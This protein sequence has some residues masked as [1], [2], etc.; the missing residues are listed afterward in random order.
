MA[1]PQLPSTTSLVDFLASQKQNTSFAARRK[2]Y[3]DLGFSRRLGEYAGSP[4]QNLNLLR[5]LQRKNQPATP[6]QP[7]GATAAVAEDPIP[8]SPRMAPS[9]MQS[10]SSAMQSL[11]S[12]PR[13]LAQTREAPLPQTT[14][15]PVA[16]APSF[17]GRA[18]DRT[19]ALRA[20]PAL[21]PIF[22]TRDVIRGL[23]GAEP[24]P[25]APTAPVTPTAPAPEPRVGISS[26]EALRQFGVTPPPP[27]P[28]VRPE[29]PVTPRAVEAVTPVTTTPE[30]RIEQADTVEAQNVDTQTKR[31]LG[32]S[33]SDIYPDI[34]GAGIAG[35]GEADLVNQWLESP[36]GRLF[37]ERQNLRGMTM[38]AKAEAS[39][40][41]LEARYESERATLEQRL[42]TNGLAFSGIRASRVKA[43]ADSLAASQLGVDR[44]LASKLLDAN[45]DL[46]DSILRGVADITKRAS[47][48]R[49]EAIQQ[50]NAVG[51][52]VVNNRLVPTLSSAREERAIRGE[53]R[54][55]EAARRAE[56]SLE[57]SER[58][59]GLAEEAAARRATTAARLYRNVIT[60]SLERGLTPEDAL[61]AAVSAADAT[62]V[63]LNVE[64]QAAILDEA[65]R[66]QPTITVQT[67][68]MPES[69][70]ET[71]FFSRLYGGG[72]F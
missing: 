57:L 50:L 64:E 41:A 72:F 18:L 22:A 71:G 27:T 45:F 8:E 47:E 13:A 20:V 31:D 49:R 63:T 38:E 6:Q 23:Q 65:Q 69:A 17:I 70:P 16:Q 52:A 14:T 4:S 12:T 1:T 19:E 11:L 43:L 34:F 51:Y 10:L 60:T 59:L 39:K 7:S 66:L 29:A 68:P 44:E 62:G 58:R 3:N 9:G 25:T 48:G 21:A 26:V 28:P 61:T 5:E 40:A 42:A 35:A 55:E 2:L 30:A 37:A 36:E 46:R 56:R 32:V 53:T 67:A 24:T 33:A 15:P 54:A